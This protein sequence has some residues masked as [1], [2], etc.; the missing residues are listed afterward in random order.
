MNCAQYI[1]P[2]ATV[3]VDANLD[4]H[5]HLLQCQLIQYIF[6]DSHNVVCRKAEM[7]K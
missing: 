4:R 6:R 1:A 3:T 5:F 7:F 2:D